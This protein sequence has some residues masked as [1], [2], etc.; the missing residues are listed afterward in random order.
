LTVYS[1]SLIMHSRGAMAISRHKTW[2]SW[3]VVWADHVYWAYH[4][5][6]TLWKVWK[7]L[8]F[9]MHMLKKG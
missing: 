2:P 5:S 1:S 8:H 7:A 6:Y 3:Y 4:V 9:I